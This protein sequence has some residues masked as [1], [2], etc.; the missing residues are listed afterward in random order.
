MQ[1]DWCK[2]WGFGSIK[3]PFGP[4]VSENVLAYAR[5]F[6]HM[7]IFLDE[8]NDKTI[9]VLSQR[10]VEAL[11]AI[12]TRIIQD[13]VNE[14]LIVSFDRHVK[15]FLSYL[16]KL[17]MHL[18]ERKGKHNKKLKVETTSNFSPLLNIPSYMRDYG[19][20]RLYWEGWF[21]GRRTTKIH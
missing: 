7:Y 15:L 1:L 4:W 17:E 18:N 10:I 21:S 9:R 16:C 8:I 3:T 13:T 20:L 11:V 6:K 5:I 2:C 12:I 14:E 19:P